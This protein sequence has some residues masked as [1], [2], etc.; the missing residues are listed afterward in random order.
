MKLRFYHG[1]L[2]KVDHRF[3]DLGPKRYAGALPVKITSFQKVCVF[4]AL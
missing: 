3:Q 4:E 2:Q 1:F